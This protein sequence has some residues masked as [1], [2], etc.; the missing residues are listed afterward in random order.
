[1]DAWVVVEWLGAIL[2]AAGAANLVVAPEHERRT[3]GLWIASATLLLAVFVADGHVA[4]AA[5][6]ATGLII[7]V[8]GAHRAAVPGRGM[9]R[10]QER[11]LEG[12]ALA[13]VGAGVACAAASAWGVNAS[14]ASA[15]WAGA[16]CSVAAPAILA[17]RC[18]APP[19]AFGVWGMSNVALMLSAERVGYDAF[20]AVNAAFLALNVAAA[21]RYLIRKPA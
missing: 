16:A 3:W 13:G 21:L 19:Y 7:N 1:M 20:A 6:Q 4:L 8:L 2:A 9:P 11:A 12:V 18:A 15:A 17:S 14:W 10:V 5:T